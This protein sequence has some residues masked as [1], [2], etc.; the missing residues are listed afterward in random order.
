MGG[1]LCE[2][3]KTGPRGH[4]PTP[5]DTGWPPPPAPVGRRKQSEDKPPQKAAPPT[6]DLVK[7]QTFVHPDYCNND[8]D[9][10]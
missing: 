1:A 3:A 8:E 10:E 7:A 4:A 6:A 5:Q 9:G 2:A